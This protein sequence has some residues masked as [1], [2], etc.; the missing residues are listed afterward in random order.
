MQIIRNDVEPRKIK[1]LF[2]Y[3]RE[4]IPEDLIKIIKQVKF[5]RPIIPEPIK[6]LGRLAG[7]SASN[8]WAISPGKT[9]SGKAMLCGDP[10]LAIQLPSIWYSALMT[11]Q[12]HYMMGATWPGVP[13][14]VLGRSPNLAW[15]VTYGTMDMID[16]FVEE[17]RDQKYRRGDQWLPFTV[18][19]EIIRPKKKDPLVIKIYEN[20]HGILEGEPDEDGYYL[21]LAWTGRKGT[22]AETANNLFKVPMPKMQRKR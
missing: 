21:S 10:H 13:S 18:R 17:V 1:K 7:F 11:S 6:W 5:F 22:A 4:D 16:Y 15:A 20:E 9:A 8:N 3:I 19:E 14:A 2:P 12:D